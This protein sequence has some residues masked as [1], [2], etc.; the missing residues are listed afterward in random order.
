MIADASNNR[1]DRWNGRVSITVTLTASIFLLVLI[2]VGS[3]LWIGLWLGQKNT[4][5]LLSQNV[6]QGITGA[7]ASVRTHLMP[8]QHQ[9]AFVASRI[10][11]GHVDPADREQLGGL[12]T[13]A[14]AAAPHVNAVMWIGPDFQTVLAARDG[15]RQF[16]GL[17]EEDYSRDAVIRRQFLRMTSEPLWTPPIWRRD[18]QDT[19]LSVA[20]PVFIDGKA[21]GAVVSVV[22]VGELSAFLREDADNNPEEA[23]R[24]FM[25]YGKGYVLAHPLL[26]EAYPGRTDERPLPRLEDFQDPILSQVWRGDEQFPLRLNVP[27]GTEGHIIRLDDE[28]YVFVYRTL[29]GFGPEPMVV[30]AWF[31]VV[32]V[33]TELRRLLFALVAGLVSLLLALIAAI[34]LGRRI[35]K[36]VVR[37]SSAASR[38]QN[39]NLDEVEPLP[40]SVFR[41]LNDQAR[42]FN[43]ML[44]GLHWFELYVPKKIVDRLVRRGE[45]REQLSSSR[46][47]VVMFTDIV[48]FSTI[49]E[50]MTAPQVAEFVNHHF[51]LVA[52]CIEAEEGTLDK[53]IGDSVMAF[54]GAPDQIEDAGQRACRAALEIARAMRADNETR[55]AEGKAPVHMRI[56]IHCGEATVGNIG[57]PGRVNYTIIGDTVNI[58]QRLEQLGKALWSEGQDISILVSGDVAAQLGDDWELESAGRHAL[59]GRT[60]DIEVFRLR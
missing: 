24:P 52:G 30:G 31:P 49:S 26:T 59:K 47:L 20:H 6:H 9:A 60:G 55:A 45:G 41:E 37:F 38:I 58:G 22:S 4:F 17:F 50:G 1:R 40:G 48:G 46:E 7:V 12:L 39:L 19:F 42:A 8:A 28:D 15:N 36:P 56:G 2:S 11:G 13:G 51:E 53:F 35:A 23:G 21:Q 25:L 32:E 16:V 14:L 44:Q 57:A 34:I 29:A 27:E 33:G 54:W 43:A 18:V 10:E 3:V 5:E